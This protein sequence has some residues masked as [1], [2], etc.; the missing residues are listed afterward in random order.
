[1]NR[2][3]K[4]KIQEIANF[5]VNNIT[6]AE[7]TTIVIERST[8]YAELI[9]KHNLDPNNFNS[10]F[11][12]RKLQRKLKELREESLP[13]QKGRSK[14]SDLLDAV[15]EDPTLEKENISLYR[16]ILKWWGAKEKTPDLPERSSFKKKS[17]SRFRTKK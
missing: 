2:A 13:E 3:Q 11:S 7:V 1:M 16:K 12:R 4:K 15:L 6:L 8:E 17:R 10:E 5:I 14:K 9:V